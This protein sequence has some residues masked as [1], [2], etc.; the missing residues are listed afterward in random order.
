MPISAECPQCGKTYHVKDDFAGKKF[1]C[2]ECEGVVSVPAGESS[3]GDPW[4]DLELGDYQDSEPADEFAASAPP[5]RA[6]GKKRPGSRGKGADSGG[7]DTIA[8]VALVLGCINLLSWCLPLCGLP[9]SIGGI[10]C[11]IMGIGS[12]SNRVLAII[13]LILSVLGLIG[14]II[15]AAIGAMMAIEGNHPL[16][17]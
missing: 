9:L 8:I 17:Q 10:V 12:P 15:N 1:R 11:G 2:K 16:L 7:K 13:G 5:R 3:S 14:T 6:A 4:D